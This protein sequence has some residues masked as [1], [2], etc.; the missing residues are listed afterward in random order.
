MADSI[1]FRI[2]NKAE[3]EAWLSNL[4]K[5]P[6]DST[7]LMRRIGLQIQS[8]VDETFRTRGARIGQA[9][10]ALRESTVMTRHGTDR[11]SYGTWKKPKRNWKQLIEYRA[12]LMR[13]GAWWP[14]K[15][16]PLGEYRGQKRY[17]GTGTPP[18]QS[19]GDF[20]RSFQILWLTKHRV[21]V[22]STMGNTLASQITRGRPVMDITHNDLL[23]FRKYTLEHIRK[24]YK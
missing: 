14:G 8:D 13:E 9:W 18:M 20:R 10:P 3:V 1:Q 12:Q 23:K 5:L 16:G 6:G 22:G 24:F 11:L 2:T 4:A 15:I 19:S 17:K 7:S 21:R